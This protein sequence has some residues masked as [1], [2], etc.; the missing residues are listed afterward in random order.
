MVSELTRYNINMAA[1]QETKWFGEEAYIVGEGL[2][3]TAGRTI[4]G[5]SAKR[6][7]CSIGLK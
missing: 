7:G 2:M 6:L 4:P 3:W 1:L 5:A